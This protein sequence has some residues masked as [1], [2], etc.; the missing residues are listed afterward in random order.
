MKVDGFMAE[1][2]KP[3]RLFFF[4]PPGVVE[5]GE[6]LLAQDQKDAER[7]CELPD[8]LE[9]L[10]AIVSEALFCVGV[11]VRPFLGACDNDR[12][13]R[14]TDLVFRDHLRCL[15]ILCNEG[16]R[17][18]QKYEK[19]LVSAAGGAPATSGRIIRRRTDSG[20]QNGQEKKSESNHARKPR[21]CQAGEEDQEGTAQGGHDD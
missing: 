7:G 4:K 21:R 3:V 18:L 20:Q 14:R 6:W 11:T 19:P 5:E 2:E 10:Y 15:S 17:L 8:G 9:K 1:T 16:W 13:L 12:P